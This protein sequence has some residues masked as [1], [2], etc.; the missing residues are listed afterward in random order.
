MLSYVRSYKFVALFVLVSKAIPSI[1][2][3]IMRCLYW[4]SQSIGFATLLIRHM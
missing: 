2:V 1:Q 4:Q 3:T